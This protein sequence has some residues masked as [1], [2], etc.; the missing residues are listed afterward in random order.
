MIDLEPPHRVAIRDDASVLAKLVD[1]AGEG[2]PLYVWNQ[3][4]G[5]GESPWDVGRNRAM[6]EHGGFS[7]RNAIVREE[8]EGVVSCLI[9]YPLEDDQIYTDPADLPK[10]F[11]PL[12]ELENQAPGTWYVNVLATFPEYR[13]RGFGAQLLLLAEQIAQLQNK[14]GLSVIVSDANPGAIRLYE[15][16]GYQVQTIR[17]MVKEDWINPG[18]NWILLIRNF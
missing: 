9:G 4:C 17:P 8:D 13:N 5:P 12:Q 7:Y 11:V 10:M 14:K 15:K 16:C 18:K 1:I 2:M 6:R 3:M